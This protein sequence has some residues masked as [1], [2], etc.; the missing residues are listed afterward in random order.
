MTIENPL[1]SL[2][3]YQGAKEQPV[4]KNIDVVLSSALVIRR[5]LFYELGDFDHDF[6]VGARWGG[7]KKQIYC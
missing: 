5:S 1:E 3:R 4:V 7:V 6:G 2:S